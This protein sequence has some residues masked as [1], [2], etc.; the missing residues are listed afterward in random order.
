MAVD[1]GVTVTYGGSLSGATVSIGAG[2]VAGQDVLAFTPQSGIT[3]A[4]DAATGVLTLTGAASAAA[5]QAALRSVTY[6]NTAGGAASTA[7]RTVTFTA[8]GASASRTLSVA[9]QQY[10]FAFQTDGTAGT[11][12][13]GTTFQWVVAGASGTPVT[14][15]PSAATYFVNW[16]G[17]GG[18][19][20]TTANP[21]T[22]A[23]ASTGQTITAHF[24]AKAVTTVTLSGPAVAP[25]RGQ[26]VTFLAVLSPP[27]SS[28]TVQFLVDGVALGGPVAVVGGQATSP[29]TATLT[30]GSH[31]V[32]AVYS[33]DTTHLTTSASLSQPVN[34]ASTATAL[35]SS[36]E[37]VG[38]RPAGDAAPRR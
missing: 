33:G 9:I 35:A 29:S 30:P 37:P 38:A 4:Y 12:L 2:F 25:V 14:A 16:T 34:P 7:N 23:N 36:A 20:T 22:V 15:V 32:S 19:V 8:G 11:T 31:A 3:G 18:F 28:G 26:P 21:L 5:Y 10:S 13:T 27:A 6:A 24:A 1:P 17:D